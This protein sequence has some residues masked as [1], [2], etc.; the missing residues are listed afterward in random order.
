ME[1]NPSFVVGAERSGT[2]LFRLMLN[3]HP[4]IAVCSEFEYIVDLLVGREDWPDLNQVYDRLRSN[5]I[6]QGHNF[7]IDPALSY[8][9]LANSF[10]QQVLQRQQAQQVIGVVHRNFDQLQRIWPNAR[11]IHIVRDPRDV[12]RSVIG[13]GWAGNVW[14]G[15]RFWVEVEQMWERMQGQL[16]DDRFIEIKY[17]ELISSPEAV[18]DQVCQFLGTTFNP[19]M[20]EYHKSTTYLK[21]NS[22]LIQQWEKKLYPYEVSLVESRVG[23]LLSQ[24]GYQLSGQPIRHP[25]FVEKLWLRVQSKFS[26]LNYRLHQMGLWLFISEYISR[27][28]NIKPWQ[29]QLDPQIAA[30]WRSKLK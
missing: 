16:S 18:L 27:K 9:D 3:H 29:E 17:E 10:L 7:S 25:S 5:W 6:F 24:R 19:S 30:I 28:L 8:P 20:L 1:I 11:Y 22:K 13:M 15:V 23:T 21:P 26:R 4:E 12:A 14:E 2:T